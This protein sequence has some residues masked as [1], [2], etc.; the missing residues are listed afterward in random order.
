MMTERRYR[1]RRCY[2]RISGDDSGV[3][4][5]V[6]SIMMLGIIMTLIG[7]VMTVYLPMWARSNEVSHLEDVS[8]SFIDLKITIDNQIMTND[9]GSKFNT[10]IKLGAGGGPMLGIGR[11]SGSIDFDSGRSTITVY[12]TED[13]LNM[14]GEGGGNLFYGSNNN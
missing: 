14:F 8:D 9:M 11:S 7:M 10:R 2:V 4:N 3:S 6:S 1:P 5:I 13:G 12:Q